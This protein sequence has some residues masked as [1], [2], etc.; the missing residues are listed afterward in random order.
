MNQLS[1][2]G[3]AINEQN[4]KLVRSHEKTVSQIVIYEV[5]RVVAGKPRFLTDHLNRLFKSAQI[6]GITIWLSVEEIE[7]RI[8]LL[9]EQNQRT[10]G[11]IKLEITSE[12]ENY[13]FVESFSAYFIEH[14][15][16]TPEQYE[17]GVST[18]LLSAE[19]QM[20]NAKVFQAELRNL[21]NQMIKQK[22]VYEVILV[23]V[24]GFITEGSRSNIFFVQNNEV[25][26]SPLENVLQGVTRQ[27]IVELCLSNRILLHEKAVHID[28]LSMFQAA[29]ITG[30]SPQVL[31]ISSI[32]NVQFDVNNTVLR[33]LMHL[34]DLNQK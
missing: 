29:F 9:I 15:Y 5:F 30:T 22:N 12:V 8:Y 23:N 14:N 24:E 20:P 17:N 34:F 6:L 21:A 27:K 11:N 10:F 1:N 4:S 32:E 19:R 33:Q 25:F 18:V 26:T 7:K 31:P 28:Q 16:P 13:Q 3:S 2:I